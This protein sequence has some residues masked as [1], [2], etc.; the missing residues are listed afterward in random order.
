MPDRPDIFQVC[1]DA[2]AGAG[3]DFLLIGGHAVNAHGFIRTTTDFDFLL[4]SRDLRAWSEV[5]DHAG[6]RLAAP[7]RPIQAF[8]QFQPH[9]TGGFRVDL[10]LVEDPTF[11]KLLAGSE[12]REIGRRRVRV[13][14]VLHLIALKLHALQAPH[15]VEAGVD[16][17]D[18]LQLVRSRGIDIA[19]AEFQ[20]MINRYASPAIRERLRRDL[21]QPL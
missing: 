20:E 13:I 18:I 1:V 14:G 5:L 7:E 4:A 8:A 16:Y 3:L 11:A 2:A 6:Y 17:L 12:W 21:G 10:M 9:E 19:G 15:R